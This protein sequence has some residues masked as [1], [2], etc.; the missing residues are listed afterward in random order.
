MEEDD[1]TAA[2]LAFLLCFLV[3]DFPLFFVFFF[4]LRVA[5][6]GRNQLMVVAGWVKVARGGVR[7]A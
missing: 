1:Q 5:G 6:R 4:L 3:A 2:I 7:G